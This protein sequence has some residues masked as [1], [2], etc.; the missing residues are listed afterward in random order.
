MEEEIQNKNFNKEDIQ[1]KNFSNRNEMPWLQENYQDR[2]SILIND[3]I[4]AS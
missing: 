3:A 2:I 1:N 4:H